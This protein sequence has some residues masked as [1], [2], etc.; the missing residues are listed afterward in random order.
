MCLRRLHARHFALGMGL[1]TRAKLGVRSADLRT[2][3]DHRRAFTL[4]EL[5]VVVAIIAILMGLLLAAVQKVRESAN[6][7]T[8]ANHL[9]QIGLALQMHHDTYRAFPSNGGWDGIQKIRAT[10]GS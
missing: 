8:C 9:R 3:R 1:R 2:A 4:I 6:R 7:T 10:D 5:L